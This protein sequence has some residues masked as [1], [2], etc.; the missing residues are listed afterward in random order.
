[1]SL[2]YYDFAEL[3]KFT[4]VRLLTFRRKKNHVAAKLTWHLLQGTSSLLYKVSRVVLERDLII[5][6]WLLE[7]YLSSYWVRPTRIKDEWKISSCWEIS[8]FINWFKNNLFPV[9]LYG[10]FLCLKGGTRKKHF[11]SSGVN[12]F[13]ITKFRR[14]W[15]EKQNNFPERYIT[16]RK[17]SK[18]AKIVAHYDGLLPRQLFF[19]KRVLLVYLFLLIFTIFIV[20]EL[21]LS[22]KRKQNRKPSREKCYNV[23]ILPELASLILKKILSMLPSRWTN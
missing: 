11:L 9:I 10:S 15:Y 3:Q 17:I 23:T 2:L 1:M 14:S 13:K 16:F 4:L 6:A 20:C 5:G 12:I 21:L 22:E 8:F 7:N 19:F 18:P